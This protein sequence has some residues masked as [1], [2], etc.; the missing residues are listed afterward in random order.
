MPNFISLIIR[1]A[2]KVVLAFLGL[3]FA[4]SLLLAAIVLLL[5]SSLK[6]LVTGKKPVPFVIFSRFKKFTSGGVWASTSKGQNNADVV[7][8]EAREVVSREVSADQP[9]LKNHHQSP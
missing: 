6:W 1:F 9:Q 7:D 8:V 2:I 4:I 5:F 3:I